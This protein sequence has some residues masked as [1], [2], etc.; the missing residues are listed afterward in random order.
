VTGGQVPADSIRAVLERVFA[1]PRYDWGAAPHPFRWSLD[2]WRSL[3]AWLDHLQTAHPGVYYAF[4]GL[5]LGLLI[6]ILTHFSLLVWRALKP[7]AP[8]A[9]STAALV[10]DVRNAV[11]H[12]LAARRLIA[13]RRYAEALA[14][15]FAAMMLELDRRGVVVF[16][17]SKTPGEYRQ[18]VRL[19]DEGRRTFGETVVALYRH[20]FG[21]VACTLEDVER[22]SVLVERVLERGAA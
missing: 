5:M 9:S 6:A 8:P 22:F 14:H 2:L 21:G 16:R 13:E 18:E 12:H 11:W 3:L 4:L 17:P 7:K 19:D 1:Q 20:V 10:S 15:R